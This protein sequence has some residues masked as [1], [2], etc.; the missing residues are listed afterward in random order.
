MRFSFSLL[1]FALFACRALGQDAKDDY[2]VEYVEPFKGK[3][4]KEGDFVSTGPDVEQCVKFEA[5]GLRI[6]LPAGFVGD[7]ARTGMASTF[8]VKG[9]FEMTVSYEILQEPAPADAG[10]QTRLAISVV[11]DKPFPW[12]NQAAL[13]RRVT[14]NGPNYFAWLTRRDVADSKAFL[15]MESFPTQAKIGRLRLIRRGQ[16]LSFLATVGADNDFLLLKKENFGAEDVREVALIGA[17]GS[18]RAALDARVTDLRIRAAA[19]TKP[20][21]VKQVKFVPPPK[22]YAKSYLH[23]FKGGP[24][25]YPGW[26]FEGPGAEQLVQFE[27]KGLLITLPQGWQGERPATGLRSRFGVKGDFEITMSFEILQEPRQEV[28]GT[29][30]STRLNLAITKEAPKFNVTTISRSMSRTNGQRFVSWSSLWDEAEGRQRIESNNTA[31]RATTGRLRLV[32]S[33]VE[34][35]YGVSEG[36]EGEFTYFKKSLFGVEDI[37]NVRIMTSTGGK[38]ASYDVRV[39]DLRIRADEIPNMPEVPAAAKVELQEGAPPPPPPRRGWIVAA[40]LLGVGLLVLLGAAL[41]MWFYLQRRGL[42]LS[43]GGRGVRGEG[44]LIACA[45]CGKKWTVIAGKKSKCPHC[46]KTVLL[47]EVEAGEA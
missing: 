12:Q 13:N 11:L 1:H 7:R 6:T 22:D 34:V 16:L 47:P 8:G 36:F 32:R 21:P 2:A 17:T 10:S 3:P 39:T 43:P 41:G 26:D 9:D 35:F 37:R 15:R 25:I 33:G 5:E 45:R 4:A 31:T 46:S 29:A 28:A 42:P 20:G 19:L 27:A 44:E 14:T 38:E 18:D 40:V 30:N 24:G 23:P